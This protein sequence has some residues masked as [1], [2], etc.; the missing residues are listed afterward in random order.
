MS[1]AIVERRGD[2]D[3]KDAYVQ[4]MFKGRK[5]R[6]ENSKQFRPHLDSERDFISEK[7]FGLDNP[8]W[9]YLFTPLKKV[10]G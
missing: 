4:G 6:N 10:R 9:P 5:F 1:W 2:K 8:T 3:W 7:H